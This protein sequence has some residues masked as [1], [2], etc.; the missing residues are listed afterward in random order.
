M[1]EQ[2]LN[3]KLAEW[4]GFEFK[5]V[6]FGVEVVPQWHGLDYASWEPPIFTQSLDACFKW[7]V[8]KAKCDVALNKINAGWWC[9]IRL[10]CQTT[11]DAQAETPALA[12]CLAIEK[13]IDSYPSSE[14]GEK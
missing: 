9:F 11:F 4:A 8:P 14:K 10:D 5:G 12:L 6:K 1:D 3:R 2:E 13:L 7:L